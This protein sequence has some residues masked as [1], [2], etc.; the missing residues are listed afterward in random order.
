MDAGPT[1]ARIAHLIGERG[2]S[3]I[4]GALM[5]GRAL[6]ATEL[7]DAAGITRPT[8]STH[9]GKLERARLIVA[10]KQGRHR[11]FRLAGSEV[12]QLLENMMG[13]ANSIADDRQFGPRD[14]QLRKARVCYDHLA[15]TLGV[16]VYDGLVRR[17][18]LS[19]TPEGVAL[20]ENGW[21]LFGQLNLTADAIA[22]PRRP[23]CRACIDWSERRHHLA[24]GLGAALL[25]R[26]FELGWASPIRDSRVVRFSS[27]GEKKLRELFAA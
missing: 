10:E 16:L 5:G 8:V 21:T 27:S 9:L 20:A 12:A 2:R 11:Y 15:G 22:N 26:L 3:Q 25:D 19:V 13:V 6:T 24:G 14:P 23:L 7:A 17:E 18:L 4:L 1:I